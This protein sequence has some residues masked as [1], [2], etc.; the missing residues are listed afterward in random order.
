[1]DTIYQDDL[2]T[3]IHGDGLEVVRSLAGGEKQDIP[4]IFA[5]PK[6]NIG[7]GYDDD[8][9]NMTPGKYVAWLQE[10]VTTF[11]YRSRVCWMSFN[12]RYTIP[13]GKIASALC[14]TIDVKPCV[15]VF[16]FGQHN[17]HDLGNNH[18]PLWRFSKPGRVWNTDAIRVE[19]W[20]QKNGDKRA[21]PRGRVPGDVFDFPRVVGNSKQRQSWHPT[22]LDEDLVERCILMSTKPGDLVV[23]P[24]MGTGTTARVCRKIG[25]R[26]VTADISLNYCEQVA[27]AQKL[28]ARKEAA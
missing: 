19:S 21:D 20:R 10:C 18:R 8:K 13:M 26:C 5:D 28:L 12:S 16:T 22:Q 27:K 6:D 9:D 17:Q 11:S 3:V 15:Q 23:D 24:F 7:L 14:V 2:I 4:C 25:R 1:M